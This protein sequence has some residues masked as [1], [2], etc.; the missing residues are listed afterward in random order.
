MRVGILGGGQLGRMLALAGYPLGV[1]C[2]VLDP[3]AGPVRRPGLRP[4]PRRVRRLPGALP[5]RPG[6]G[7]RHLRVRERPGRVGP[8]AGRAGAG[9]PAAAGAGGVA[10]PARREDVLPVASASRRRRSPRSTPGSEFD[11]AV[12]EIGLPAV[13]KTRRFGYDGKGQVGHPHAG[14]G[15][16]GVGEARR[17]AAHPRRVRAVRPRA[18]DHRRPRP[19]R[20]RSSSTRWSRTNTATASCTA[21]VAPAGDTAARS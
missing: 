18:V 21:S 14:R 7:R 11:A 15:R 10:G 12:R 20:A 8:V 16:G 13:L 9:L 17:P 3:A 6:V 1:R 2:T 19:G 5:A 4:H